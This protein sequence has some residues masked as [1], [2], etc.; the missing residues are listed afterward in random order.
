MSARGLGK[1]IEERQILRKI[2]LE[3]RPGEFVALLGANGAG[4]STLLKVLATLTPAT[5]GALELFGVSARGSAGAK[6]AASRVDGSVFSTPRQLG[7]TMRM[8]CWRARRTSSA[9][10]RPPPA[11]TSLK[12]AVRITT[13]RTPAVAASAITDGTSAAG[14]A[15]TARS[16]RSGIAPIVGNAG[17]PPTSVACG[18]TA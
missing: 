15:M 5:D 17:T 13:A 10:R 1:A 4:K 11:S 9:W 8:P 2:D 18:F 16:T 12:P 14:T 7:P 6:V 3:I